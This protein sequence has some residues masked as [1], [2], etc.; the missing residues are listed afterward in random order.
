MFQKAKRIIWQQLQRFA[1]RKQWREVLQE[2]RSEERLILRS[3]DTSCMDSLTQAEKEAYDRQWGWLGLPPSYREVEVFKHFNG[4]D[5][6]YLSHYHYLPLIARRLNDYPWTKRFE[7]KALLG[8]FSNEALQPPQTFAC[9]INGEWYDADF[10]QISFEE[11]VRHCAS[12]DAFV[13]KPAS[14]SADGHGVQLVKRGGVDEKKWD[15]AVSAALARL[16]KDALVQEAVRQAPEMAQFNSSSLNTLRV[17]SLYL[18]GR[19]SVCSTVLRMGKS[20]SFVDNRSAGGIMLGVSPDGQLHEFGYDAAND[21]FAV[22]N[23]IRFAET[24]LA[25]VP[26][27][28]RLIEEVHTT[29]FSLCKFIGWD[30]AYE[31]GGRP[32]LIEV[33]S[34]QPGVFGEQLCT[35]PIFGER[36]DEVI[37]YCRTKP[38]VYG[39]ALASY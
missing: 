9:A 30:I 7:H 35:G 20:G 23:G 39:R 3:V 29:R 27:L 28:L 32:V 22:S 26:A 16:P 17:T 25:C 18:N 2:S 37:A 8:R 38:F 36:T 12:Q 31:A 11:A 14:E 1:E 4:F 10:R 5:P 19:F 21:R 13:C 24:R 15:A 33:N 6:R 34:S